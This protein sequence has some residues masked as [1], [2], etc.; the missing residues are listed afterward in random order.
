TGSNFFGDSTDDDETIDLSKEAAELLK[1]T[2]T[3]SSGTGTDEIGP[4]WA[5]S[6]VKKLNKFLVLLLPWVTRNVHNLLTKYTHLFH[7]GAI[8]LVFDSLLPL[9]LDGGS[10][11]AKMEHGNYTS[12]PEIDAGI[13]HSLL[14]KIMHK[15][16][17]SPS[18]QD[19]LRLLVIGD[20]LAIG[21]GCVEEFDA[22]KDNT[23]PMALIEKLEDP[24]DSKRPNASSKHVAQ[25]PAFPRALARAL[26]YH[27][28]QPVQWRSAGVDGGDVHDIRLF[29]MD[30]VKQESRCNHPPDIIV[31]LFGLN[32][33]KKL[34]SANPLH[35]KHNAGGISQFRQGM[36]RLLSD[37]RL[38][39][40]YALVAFPALPITTFHKNSIVGIF[41]LGLVVDGVM[42]LWERQKKMVSSTGS[43]AMYV[44]LT[45]KEISDWYSPNTESVGHLLNDTVPEHMFQTI[46]TESDAVTLL[47][48][49]GVH[50]NKRMYA[51]W[52]EEV[53]HKL[54]SFVWLQV[55]LQLEVKNDSKQP[56]AKF[57]KVI[58]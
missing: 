10:G 27:F 26:S 29:C 30:V 12:H 34:L 22:S 47:S 17:S 36:E 41:P 4:S 24:V 58:H 45:A 28:Q 39:A 6:V 15:D 52:A 14:Q 3:T 7:I 40:P 53:G 25:S 8:F 35:L 23:V 21:L 51:K 20:S 11:N 31:V 44:E 42:G 19:P 16:I 57:S 46:V 56:N 50:P 38:C 18:R 5:A 13:S 54:C 2:D 55:L 43:N 9:T 1:A 33:L 49:D 48:P 37:I 32:D